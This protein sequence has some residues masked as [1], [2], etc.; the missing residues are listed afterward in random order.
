MTD[1][2]STVPSIRPA[3]ELFRSNVVALWSTTYNIDLSLFNEFLLGRLGNPPLNVAILADA[4]RIATTLERIPAEKVDQVAAVNCRWLLREARIGG[5]RFH[6]KSYLAVTP[7][8]ATLLV[9]SG[10][11]STSG[12]DEG[13][14]VFTEFVSGTPVGDAAID[15]WFSWMRRLVELIDDTRL[16]ERFADLE[17]KLPVTA[18]P[19]F[20]GDRSLLHNLDV[21]LLEQ[22]VDVIVRNDAV[23]V[24][25]LWVTAPFFDKDALALQ[26]LMTRLSPNSISLFTTSTTSV[27]GSQLAHALEASGANVNLFGYEPDEFTHA[28]LIGLISGSQGWMFSGSANVSR[29]ALTM[30]ASAGNVELSVLTPASPEEVRALFMPPDTT[31]TSLSVADLASLSYS[32]DA[33]TTTLPVRLQHATALANGFVEVRCTPDLQPGWQLDDLQQ[34]SALVIEGT[35]TLTAA[36]IQ[37]RLVR[38]VDS[39]GTVLSN[40]AVV[41][42]PGGLDAALHVHSH[43][44]ADHPPELLPGDL[45]GP[46]GKALLWVHQ[47]FVMD[48][49]EAVPAGAGTGGVGSGEEDA[50]SD[51]DLWERLE[52]EKLGRD[53]RINTYRRILGRP[54]GL[55]ASELILEL[56]E[57]MRDRVPPADRTGTTSQPTSILGVL[58]KDAEE[59]EDGETPRKLWKTETR[60]RVRARNVLRRWAAAQTDPRLVWIDHLA[61]AGNFSMIATMFAELWLVIGDDPAR[62]ELKADDLDDLWFD[63][64]RPFVG[65][66]RGDGWLDQVD[67][68]DSAVRG[69]IPYE[70][71]ETV[72]AL[73]W[74][75]L[76]QKGRD[77]TIA[78]QPVLSAAL[79]H[80]LLEPSDETARF[81]S[82]VT[83]SS[84]TCSEVEE[85]LLR[86]IEFIDDDLWCERTCDELGL[87]GL[88][89]QAVSGGQDVSVRLI[90]KGPVNPL[91]DSRIPQLIVTARRYRRCDG[92]AVSSDDAGW[93]LAI[94]T[95]ASIAYRPDE[96]SSMVESDELTAGVIERMAST[97]GILADLFVRDEVA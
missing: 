32:S 22:L 85:E 54:A 76:R 3:L 48:V 74:L 33:D 14:E 38:I 16:A 21:P 83:H 97:G 88:Q 40:R 77:V 67:L 59:E 52:R 11:L 49:T 24:D 17:A 89:L 31:A 35:R 72:S 12:L 73:C 37:G 19:R 18:G 30:A 57:A 47:N 94:N 9:G 63:W 80:R 62:C 71:P 1:A 53:P 55:G 68:E 29:A 20:A 84:T 13:R 69:R 65:S 95:G 8:T 56:L 2:E 5:G 26:G 66:G 25:E 50:T 51:D 93:R 79:G 44:T 15:T 58:R 87:D 27:D 34:C 46:L 81:V 10:N 60:V 86:C 42:D 41:D 45:D 61:P 75:A 70:L 7:T 43:S 78:W 82:A 28:K 23:P 90:V 4:E 91:Q 96:V 36:P 64:M 39:S 92:V 6:P